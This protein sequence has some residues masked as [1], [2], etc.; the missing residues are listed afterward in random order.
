MLIDRALALNPNLAAAWFCSGWVRVC[1]GEPEA[2]IK[3]LA[4]AIRLSPFDPLSGHMQAAIATAH[5]F[6]GRYDEASSWAEKALREQPTYATALQ[7]AA[8]SNAL[9][10]RL[11]EA[12]KAMERLHQ[13]DPTLRL[14]ISEIGSLFGG[15]KTS[16]GWRR[17]CDWPAC[18]NDAGWLPFLRPSVLQRRLTAV[19]GPNNN[20]SEGFSGF[21]KWL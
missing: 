8:A 9:A 15:R 2:A 1:L 21:S 7:A 6:A 5:F 19:Q 18:R 12:Q 3:H 13:A 10:G 17:V 4:Y 20:S 11:K 14:P 16:P